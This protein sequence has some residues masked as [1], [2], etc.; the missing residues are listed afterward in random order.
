MWRSG[1]R[2]SDP[3]VTC[4]ACGDT[5][6]RSKA[7]EYDK[8]GDRWDRADKDFEY[9]CKPCDRECCHQPRQG[10]EALLTDIEAEHADR[11]SQ[12]AFLAQYLDRTEARDEMG[13]R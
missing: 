1:D 8:Y 5:V 13:E 6:P 12:E 9:L 2:G 7:R 10:L 4:I 11:P 3:E